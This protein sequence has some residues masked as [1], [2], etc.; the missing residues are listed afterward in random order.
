M[1]AIL[2]KQQ[3]IQMISKKSWLIYLQRNK[4]DLNVDNFVDASNGGEFVY[5]F[6]ANFTEI[7][8]KYINN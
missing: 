2:R 6:D 8:E 3:L 1:N 5:L 4:L 7:I